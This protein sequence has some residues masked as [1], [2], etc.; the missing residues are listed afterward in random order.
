MS[1]FRAMGAINVENNE[2]E[3]DRKDGSIHIASFIKY[4]QKSNKW[5]LLYRYTTLNKLDIGDNK[6]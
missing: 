3:Q 1:F 5:S 6:N 2:L 4:F